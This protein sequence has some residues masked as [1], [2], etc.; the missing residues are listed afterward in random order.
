MTRSP[1]IGAAGATSGSRHIMNDE[2]IRKS[3]RER[4]VAQRRQPALGTLFR[5]DTVSRSP[6]HLG[7]VWNLSTSGI[8]MLSHEAFQPG[9]ELR[10]ELA[11]MDATAVLPVAAKVVHLR[12]LETGDY[13]VGAH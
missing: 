9:T 4:R 2:P 6:A 10:G 7:L 11:T 8:S 3:S 12:K 1:T 5:L 13:M